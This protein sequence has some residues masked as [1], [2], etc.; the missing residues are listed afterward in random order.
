MVDSGYTTPTGRLVVAGTPP[1]QTYHNVGVAT[2]MYPGR[3]VVREAGDYDVKVGDGILPPRGF[4]GYETASAV[5]RPASTSTIWTVDYEA[6]VLR[7]GGF[8]IYM[9]GGLALGTYATAGDLLASWGAGQVVPCALFDGKIGVKIPFTKST[10]QAD[11]SVDIPTGAI[12]RDAIVQVVTNAASSTI[13]IG[14]GAG[15]ESGFDADGLLDGESCANTGLV[16]HNTV[17]GTA[18]NNTLGALLVESDIKS[19]DGTA[20]YYSVPNGLVCDGT[21]VSVD[22][23][24]SNHTVAGYFYVV[25][26][27]PGVQVVGRAGNTVDATSAAGNIFVES[28]L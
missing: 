24:T 18:A 16:L 14:L 4:L 11:T 3:L 9:P 25:L 1:I 10:S 7:G 13:D 8:T 12:I 17:D 22:Y 27:S 19:A 23:T 2:N 20:L 15:T 5:Y 21:C 26:E 28:V 6:P